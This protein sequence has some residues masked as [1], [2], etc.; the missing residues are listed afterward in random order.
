MTKDFACPSGI[1]DKIERS[2]FTPVYCKDL[3][4]TDIPKSLGDLPHTPLTC[5][6]ARISLGIEASYEHPRMVEMPGSP[7]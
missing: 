5:G 3:K 6:Y 7:L 1:E 4:I 2:V